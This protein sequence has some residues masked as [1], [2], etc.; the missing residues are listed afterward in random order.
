MSRSDRFLPKHVDILL[1]YLENEQ[2]IKFVETLKRENRV[3]Q[4]KDYA[5][6]HL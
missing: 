6:L 3:L 2:K 5:E 4:I 1:Q